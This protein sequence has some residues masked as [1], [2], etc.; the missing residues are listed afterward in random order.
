[1]SAPHLPSQR[2]I[3]LFMKRSADW[4]S[5]W[6]FYLTAAFLFGAAVLR[7]LLIF[8]DSPILSQVLGLPLT[9]LVLFASETTISR[10]WSRYFAIYVA[11]QTGVVVLLLSRPGFTEFAHI[12]N[13]CGLTS[14]F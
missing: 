5:Q 11:L 13:S 3:P 1:M 4:S 9:W 6:I 7:S 12:Q 10:K 14:D 8:R 2:Q